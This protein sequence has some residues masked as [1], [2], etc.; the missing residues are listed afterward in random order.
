[1]SSDPRPSREVAYRVFA[2]EYEDATH[3]YKESEEERAPNYVVTPSGARVNRLFVVG[4]LTELERVGDDDVLRARVVDPTGAFVV[5]A[6]QY[7]P[8]PLAVLEDAEPPSFVA[9]TGKANTFTPEGSERTFSSIRPE[10][11]THVD[12]DTRDRWV[13][14]TAEHTLDRAAFMADALGREERGD[15][16]RAALEADDV[17]PH[18]AAG[19]PRALDAY[20]TRRAYLGALRELSIDAARQVAG[21][22]DE[23]SRF[24]VAPDDQSGTDVALDTDIGRIRRVPTGGADGTPA[25]DAAESVESSQTDSPS[26]D[27][28]IEPEPGAENAVETEPA[29]APAETEALDEEAAGPPDE[30]Q[31]ETGTSDADGDGATTAG[32]STAAESVTEDELYELD[33][34]EREAVES[35]YGV[36]FTS[37][38]DIPD[39]GEAELETPD[40]ESSDEEAGESTEADSS[41]SEQSPPSDETDLEDLVIERMH[42]L[43]GGEGVERSAL[44]EDVTSS[45]DIDEDAVLEAI[46]AALMSGRCY[47]SGEDELTPI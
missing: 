37:G 21:E 5:Y 18:L 2:A 32:D 38:T 46:Q 28:P 13:V 39:A 9:V 36:E 25:A 44:I 20:G 35:E 47:E 23:V 16:L 45:E 7:Q 6:G 27:T 41:S 1:V 12:A 15:A 24:D 14:T 19:I 33:E 4:V 8:E 40:P 11:V 3:S 34:E 30:D 22:I 31:G 42:H 26:A 43:G 17:P 29:A 10:S